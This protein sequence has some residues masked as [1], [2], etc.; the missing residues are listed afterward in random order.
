MANNTKTSKKKEQGKIRKKEKMANIFLITL[1][2]VTILTASIVSFLPSDVSEDYQE[3]NNDRKY[4]NPIIKKYYC[5]EGYLLDGKKCYK[6]DII[7]ATP[8]PYCTVGYLSGNICITE[9]YT[10]PQTR[11][12]CPIGYNLSGLRCRK[13]GTSINYN[14]CGSF[15]MTYSYATDM[16]YAELYPT[17][18][19]YCI[20]GELRGSSCVIQNYTAASYYYECP[21]EYTL[22]DLVCEKEIVIDASIK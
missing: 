2:C 13:N 20:I 10:I 22:H 12:T 15:N 9:S 21:A 11:E 17:T 5:P 3:S 18:T 4:K 7:A 16:C 19:Q 8:T 14:K 6:T 1:G